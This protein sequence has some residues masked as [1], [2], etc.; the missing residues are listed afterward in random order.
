[1]ILFYNLPTEFWNMKLVMKELLTTTTIVWYN[2]NIIYAITRYCKKRKKQYSSRKTN[3]TN[4]E[5]RIQIDT[6]MLVYGYFLRKIFSERE[7][8]MKL[9]NYSSYDIHLR[10]QIRSQ[11]IYNQWNVKRKNYISFNRCVIFSFDVFASI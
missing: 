6:E 4:S 11:I 5:N 10:S 3:Q 2:L 7:L 9:Q 1:M 8:T